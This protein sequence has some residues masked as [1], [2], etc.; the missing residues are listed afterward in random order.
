M[1][2][3]FLRAGMIAGAVL[4]MSASAAMADEYVVVYK[5][6][7]S[8]AA[9]HQ[10]IRD[11]GGT[12]VTTSLPCTHRVVTRSS[13]VPALAAGVARYCLRNARPPTRAEPMVAMRAI[14]YPSVARSTAAIVATAPA[15][16]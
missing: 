9:A 15:S 5:Q 4:A 8:D 3:V 16:E 10:A 7:V 12:I 13:V 6:G 14:G 1:P 2:S 11:A